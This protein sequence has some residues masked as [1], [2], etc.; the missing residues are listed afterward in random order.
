MKDK[1]EKWFISVIIPPKFLSAL[2]TQTIYVPHL[3]LPDHS[4]P[5]LA[6]HSL[7][8]F[9]QHSTGFLQVLDRLLVVPD[10]VIAVLDRV[11]VVLDRVLAV[12]HCAFRF[13]DR[14]LHERNYHGPHQDP[15]H[16]TQPIAVETSTIGSSRVKL[17]VFGVIFGVKCASYDS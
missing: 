12:P 15:S 13:P 7:T 17:R 8:G 6:L 16:S 10:L 4:S 3:P 5:R 1:K 9:L 11:L 14:V 2:E